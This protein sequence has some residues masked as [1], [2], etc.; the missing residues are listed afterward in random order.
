M[1][2]VIMLDV[3]VLD[4]VMLDVAM[5]DVVML[6]VAMLDVIMLNV[7]MLNVIILSV[8]AVARHTRQRGSADVNPASKMSLFRQKPV[9]QESTA[10]SFSL[11]RWPN[12]T[13]LIYLV[14]DAMLRQIKAGG[15]VAGH[16]NTLG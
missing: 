8:A 9:A 15:L 2:D 5:L 3:V 1:L 11:F 12:V 13:K 4:V 7:V 6:D 14:T 16:L 10:I